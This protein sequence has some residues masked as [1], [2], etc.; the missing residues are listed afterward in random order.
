MN[1]ESNIFNTN[2]ND[3]NS[4]VPDN[5]VSGEVSESVYNSF[6]LGE[7]YCAE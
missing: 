4:Y 6:S 3:L 2:N 7:E 1:A 5:S